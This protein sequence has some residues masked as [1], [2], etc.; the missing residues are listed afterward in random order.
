MR[1]SKRNED[2]G[3]GEIFWFHVKLNKERQS[4]ESN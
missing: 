1:V 2:Q 4:W 3:N